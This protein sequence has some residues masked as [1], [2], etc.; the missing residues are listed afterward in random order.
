MLNAIQGSKKKKAEIFNKY[1]KAECDRSH[2]SIET[3]YATDTRGIHTHMEGLFPQTSIY[4]RKKDGLQNRILEKASFMMQAWR[5]RKI[6][7]VEKIQIPTEIILPLS[8][9]EQKPKASK[10]SITHTVT[11]E[12]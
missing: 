5:S 4:A 12:P 2:M 8:P 9:M 3:R 11:L 6:A 10:G 7:T 1:L